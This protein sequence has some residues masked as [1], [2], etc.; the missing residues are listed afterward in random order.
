VKYDVTPSR[1]HISPEVIALRRAVIS[2]QEDL[3]HRSPNIVGLLIDPSNRKTSEIAVL[4]ALLIAYLD[5]DLQF[6]TYIR[7][8]AHRISELSVERRLDR[9]PGSGSSYDEA[10]SDFIANW[11]SVTRVKNALTG[12]GQVRVIDALSHMRV[13]NDEDGHWLPQHIIDGISALKRYVI[14]DAGFLKEEKPAS[15]RQLIDSGS[16]FIGDIDSVSDILNRILNWM[17]PPPSPT[18]ARVGPSSTS[19][20]GSR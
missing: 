2:L 20:A 13:I 12:T 15:S 19:P 16:E 4:Y 8:L 7:D 9:V 18:F 1:D 6:S 11:T 3:R 14:F 17:G 5:R 10:L